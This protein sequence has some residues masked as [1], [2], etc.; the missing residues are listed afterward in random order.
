VLF[1]SAERVADGGLAAAFRRSGVQAFR[2]PG[3]ERWSVV[4]RRSSGLNA[5]D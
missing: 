4:G 1:R 3:V 2:R 5:A